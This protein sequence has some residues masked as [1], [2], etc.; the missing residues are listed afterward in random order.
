MKAGPHRQFGRAITTLGMLAGL[1]CGPGPAR[2]TVIFEQPT[3]SPPSA[4]GSVSDVRPVAPG[5]T[6]QAFDDLSLAGAATVT[7]A[8]WFGFYAGGVLDPTT[9]RPAFIL[10]FYSDS[11][12]LP[13]PTPFYEANVEATAGTTATFGVYEFSA[14]PIPPAALPGNERIWFSVIGDDPAFGF[15]FVWTDA[16]VGG[17]ALTLRTSDNTFSLHTAGRA[18]SLTSGVPEPSAL[19]LL[20]AG[21]L[22]VGGLASR[23]HRRG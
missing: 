7:D 19:L 13:S 20:G 15:F 9:A 10:R 12:G 2:A 11:S 8:H 6:F 3:S 18:F 1:V 4:S 14:D 5:S 16:I 21:I 22:S 23:R 17:P